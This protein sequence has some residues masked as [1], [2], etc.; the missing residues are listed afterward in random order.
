[1]STRIDHAGVA[2]MLKSAGVAA[3]VRKAANAI[4]ANVDKGSVTE[5]E[6]T[7]K[8]FVT[9][10]AISVVAIAHPAGIA[11]EAKHGTLRKAAAIAG[12]EVKAKK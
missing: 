6:V 4:A 7:V 10:R 3:D 11:M 12:L 8:D 1:M 2:Q 5:A 9:D